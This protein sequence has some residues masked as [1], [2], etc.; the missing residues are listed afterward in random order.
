MEIKIAKPGHPRVNVLERKLIKKSL[1][2]GCGP[3]HGNQD[4][5][6]PRRRPFYDLDGNDA[7]VS[8]GLLGEKIIF[9]HVWA[10]N[11]LCGFP[12][13]TRL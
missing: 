7:C 4:F 11:S 9:S 12:P 8:V 3:N 1:T 5:P 6:S 10:R 2:S 13:K